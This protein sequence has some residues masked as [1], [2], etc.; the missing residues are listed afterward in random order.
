MI[1]IYYTIDGDDDI[2]YVDICFNVIWFVFDI[3]L[4][5]FLI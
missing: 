5:L 3:I 1:Y 2:Y 4:Q